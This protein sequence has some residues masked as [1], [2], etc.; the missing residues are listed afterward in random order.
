[1]RKGRQRKGVGL[2]VKSRRV[3]ER[4]GVERALAAGATV[5]P[6]GPTY[7]LA[8]DCPVR[9]A[10]TRD[11]EGRLC[12]GYGTDREGRWEMI[13]YRPYSARS[14]AYSQRRLKR[15]GR[16]EGLNDEDREGG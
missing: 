15:I 14:L 7:H 1:V 8:D 9:L 3:L 6:V 12:V 16:R 2:S 13:D 5:V 11:E 10:F 4:W